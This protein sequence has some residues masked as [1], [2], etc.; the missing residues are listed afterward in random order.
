M[1]LPGFREEAGEMI[2]ILL[3]ALLV[4]PAAV[5]ALVVPVVVINSFSIQEKGSDDPFHY[6]RY[7]FSLFNEELKNSLRKL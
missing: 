3:P 6:S 7:C 5:A 4:L 1:I 2:T